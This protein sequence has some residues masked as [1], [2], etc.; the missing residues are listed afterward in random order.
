[1]GTQV[2]FIDTCHESSAPGPARAFLSILSYFVREVFCS[3]MRLLRV[4]TRIAANLS[5]QFRVFQLLKIGV[6]TRFVCAH[7]Q[8][9][10][11][12]LSP[13]YLLRDIP[14]TT[15]TACFL[16]HYLYLHAA[17]P[18]NLLRRVLAGNVTLFTLCKD[19]HHFEIAFGR[20]R[21]VPG[22]RH[23]EHEGEMSIHLLVDNVHAYVL[24][25]TVVPGW[26][27]GVEAADVLMITRVQ[28][29]LGVFPS[30]S[31]ASRTMH[32]IP[33]EMLL[34]T[35]LQ[36]VSLALG[37]SVMAGVSAVR[38]L[39]YDQADDIIFRK[40]YDDFFDRV[41]AVRNAAGFYLA[42]FPLPEKPLALVKSGQKTRSRARRTLKQEVASSAF[43]LL[44][45]PLAI[46]TMP[47][48]AGAPSEQ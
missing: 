30:I 42:R 40:G 46:P 26:V 48:A 9:L 27:C 32:G 41:G 38:H 17:M 13:R 43:E 4:A 36:G 24:S 21:E 39:C 3:P 29:S 37:V 18:Q 11:K 28:G 16:H 10:F 8:F 23:V 31:L 5:I 14:V 12:Y 7:P 2:G 44:R 47:T 35:A 33:P 34:L 6:F 19:G 22:T 25:F 45:G 20:S 15:R 1:M